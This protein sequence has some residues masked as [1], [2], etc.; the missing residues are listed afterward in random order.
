MH[1]AIRRVVVG[2]V[3]LVVL[4]VVGGELAYW[5]AY[6]TPAF[7][8]EPKSISWCGRQYLPSNGPLLTRAA[9]DQLRAPLPGGQDEVVTVA[10]IPPLIGRPVLASVTP[11][12]TREALNLPCAMAVYLET[13]HDSYRQYILSGGP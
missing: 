5:G 2:L 7:W 12:T 4:A 8:S 1:I 10:K 6:G 13:G 3:V 11:A 9:V